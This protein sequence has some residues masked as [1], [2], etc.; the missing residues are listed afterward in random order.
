MKRG[1]SLAAH[2]QHFFSERLSTQQR[3]SPNTIATYRDTFRLLLRYAESRTGR[4]PTELQMEDIDADLVGRFLTFCE[5]QRG[6]SARSR[7]TRLA[8]IRSFF[9]YVSRNEPQLLLHCQRVLAIPAKRYDKP[10][11]NYLKQDEIQALMDARTAPSSSAA[12][13]GRCSS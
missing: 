10:V 13:T 1:H 11:I 3:A 5:T 6:N 2:I 9:N 12:A 8:G 7:N 4:S